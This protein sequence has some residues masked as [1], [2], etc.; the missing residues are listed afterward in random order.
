MTICSTPSGRAKSVCGI[1]AKEE[2]PQEKWAF[3][4]STKGEAYLRK[5]VAQVSF[6]ASETVRRPA[7]EFAKRIFP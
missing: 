4:W 2:L 1:L 7:Q 5:L 3:L 6:V